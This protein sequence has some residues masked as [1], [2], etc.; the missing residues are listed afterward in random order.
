MGGGGKSSGSDI[1][2]LMPYASQFNAETQPLV[3]GQMGQAMEALSTGGVGAKIPM[4][5]AA[6]TQSQSALSQ[7]ILGMRQGAAAQGMKNSPFTMGQIG[8]TLMQGRQQIAGIGPQMAQ[9]ALEGGQGTFGA[10][11]SALGGSRSGATS[12]K[13]SQVL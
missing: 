3:Q 7:A 11:M 6:T 8:N 5:Q 2:A 12:G 1:S 9:S 4:I 10:I 13:N